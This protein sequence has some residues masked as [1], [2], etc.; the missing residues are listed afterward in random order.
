MRA[1]MRSM[2]SR[3]RRI[4]RKFLNINSKK[5]THIRENPAGKSHSFPHLILRSQELGQGA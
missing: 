2:L 5:Q 1:C 3:I 4:E